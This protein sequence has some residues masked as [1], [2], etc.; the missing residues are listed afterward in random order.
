MGTEGQ[1]AAGAGQGGHAV[2]L[3]CMQARPPIFATAQILPEP[4]GSPIADPG[5]LTLRLSHPAPGLAPGLRAVI[6]PEPGSA[7][8]R[9]VVDV[10]SVDGC[11]VRVGTRH[12][13][14]DHRDASRVNTAVDLAY[15]PAPAGLDAQA[16]YDGADAP[17]LALH[18]P[19]PYMNLSMTGLQFE[20]APACR[21]GD[22]LLMEI[23]LPHRRPVWRALGRVVRVREIPED[24]RSE[25]TVQTVPG[26]RAEPPRQAATHQIAVH[27]EQLPDGARNALVEQTR[28]VQSGLI[29]L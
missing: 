22:L 28:R 4:A 13:R 21:E 9:R 20:D 3:V 12:L 27:F 23:R 7:A 2:T 25:S 16:W 15:L 19:D 18:R 5:A 29:G 14:A 6:D 10:L 1:G 24:Q 26:R 17:G 8:P 11:T